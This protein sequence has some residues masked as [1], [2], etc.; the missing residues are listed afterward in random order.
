MTAHLFKS[1]LQKSS[2]EEAIMIHEKIASK[3]KQLFES[4]KSESS[5]AEQEF[6]DRSRKNDRRESIIFTKI[7]DDAFENARTFFHIRNMNQLKCWMQKDENVLIKTWVDIRNENIY[8]INEF[9]KKINKMKKL[10]EKYNDWIDELND[11]NLIIRELKVKLRERNFAENI[12]ENSNTFLFIIVS[13]I[14]VFIITFKKLFD[15]SI[16]ID[17]KNSTIDD[18][19]RVMKN[20]LEENPNWFFI[21][22]EQKVYVRFKIDEDAMKHLISRFFKNSIK[23]YIISK[24]IFND[25]YQIFDDLNRRITALKTYKRLKQIES[26]KGFNTFWAE[27]Q[28]LASDSELYN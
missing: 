21:D 23:S 17:D 22:I 6:F 4:I 13:K 2:A 9:N 3:N 28:Q 19:L 15:S 8:V 24:E 16:F 27:F 12:S 1:Y 25:L 7:F 20:K 26:F 14:I 5:N 18:W 11:A 10:N